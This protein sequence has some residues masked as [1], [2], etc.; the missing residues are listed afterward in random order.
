MIFN[1]YDFSDFKENKIHI[2]FQV[3]KL[4][5][6]LLQNKAEKTQDF[7]TFSTTNLNNPDS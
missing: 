6:L 5:L 7:L 2:Y 3:M 4:F 1:V